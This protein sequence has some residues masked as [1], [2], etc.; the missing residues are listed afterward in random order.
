[1]EF[2]R[3][4]FWKN[5][6]IGV[7]W[8]GASPDIKNIKIKKINKKIVGFSLNQELVSFIRWFAAYNMMPLGLVLKMTIGN[9]LKL[10]SKNDQD[11]IQTKHITKNFI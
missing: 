11:F 10:K 9:N 7:V 5:K 1:M 2:R 6:E 4:S 3:S 8:P